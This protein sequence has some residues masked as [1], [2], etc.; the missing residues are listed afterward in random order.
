MMD[1][2]SLGEIL[3]DFTPSG[4]NEQGIS[5]FARNPGGA[6]A[7]VLAMNARLGGSSA[8]IG[9]VGKDGFG[10]YLESILNAHGIDTS[11][12]MVDTEIPTTL[13]F[14]Q[15]DEKGDR[16]FTF[17]RNPGADLQLR[18]E[19][20]PTELIDQSRIFHF[21]SVSLTDD[22][23]RTAAWNAVSYAKQAGKIVSF[24]P[25][26]RPALWKRETE[27]CEQIKKG[28][29]LAD[30]LKVSEEEM[31][32]IT[33]ETDPATGS[34]Q[35]LKMGPKAVF[36]TMGENGSYYRNHACSGTCPAL[37]VKAID[38]TGAGDAFMGAV[39]WQLKNS[40]LEEIAM[41]D[42]QNVA[43]FANTAGSLT[44]T[45]HGAI[46]ALPTAEEIQEHVHKL[47]SL[48]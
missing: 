7:N 45:R 41:C 29:A 6:P 18:W 28:I 4:E 23:C 17:Y 14:V 42:L 3:I 15:L 33:G 27:A 48:A 22:P 44:T 35:L 37:Q 30:I 32:L 8:F 25:N 10:T 19:E 20:V 46:P 12:L 5:L 11:G 31:E 43:A 9:K 24:D 26:Y 38:T 40:T 36:V 13:A 16:S 2:V 34:E 1:L 39:L 21:G 47:E